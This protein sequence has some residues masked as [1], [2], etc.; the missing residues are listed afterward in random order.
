MRSTDVPSRPAPRRPVRVL[1]PAVVALLLG[2]VLAAPALAQ[3][4][5]GAWP[6]PEGA[7]VWTLITR[8]S[9]YTRW[10]EWPEHQGLLPSTAPHGAYTRIYVSSEARR[11][12]RAPL[13]D[14]SM[15]VKENYDRDR[16]LVVLTVMYKVAGYNPE[17]GDWFWAKYAPDGAV[18]A[19]GKVGNCI[20]CHAGRA[21]ADY[22]MV[23]DF[24]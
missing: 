1:A 20:Q 18:Q 24:R 4:G 14:R 11:S 2:A 12:A 19:E 16:K 23:H 5:M 17:G 13:A 10:K 22:L 21:S 9:P 15:I 8:V 7:A 6:R 3:L